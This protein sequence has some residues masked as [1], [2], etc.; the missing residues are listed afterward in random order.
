MTA[1]LT[2]LT[3]RP[4]QR[5]WAIL[6]AILVLGGWLRT[7]GLAKPFYVDEIT[8]LT[9]AVQPLDSM[10]EVMRKIDASPALYPSLLHFWLKVSHSD[11]WAR[12]LSAVFGTATILAAFGLARSAFGTR[13]AFWA[14]FVIAIAP[15]H[16]AYAQ[17]VRN[18]S[19]FTLLAL[20]QLW[21]FLR[22]VAA[23]EPDVRPS[24]RSYVFLMLATAAMF[25]THYL[26]LLVLIPEGLFALWRLRGRRRRVLESA[27]AMVIAG[28]VF[29]PGVS[30]LQ[31]NVEFDAR[32][33]VDRATPPPIHKVLP[34]LMGELTL[35][36]RE[37]GFSNPTVRRTVLS[38]GL[39][40]FGVL[41]G[42]GVIA[43][44]RRHREA[45]ILLGSFA[46]LPILAYVVSGRTIIATRF[47]LPFGAALLIVA[48]HGLASFGRRTA[49]V[50]ALALIVM[51]AIPIRHFARDFTW[52]YDHRTVA[53]AIADRWQPG[54]IILFVHPFEAFYYQWYLGIDRPVLGLTFTPLVEQ[55]TYV[56]KPAPLD[57]EA[58]KARV[59]AASRTH[60]RLWI[61]GQSRRSFTS[62]DEAQER[63]VAAWMDEHLGRLE[64]LGTLTGGAAMVR[65]YRG[66]PAGNAGTGGSRV[67]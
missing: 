61:V 24:P 47:F 35:G 51:C 63:E 3:S 54:D 29:L 8:T 64:D 21:A 19:L 26:S 9:V 60:D 32:R 23:G 20:L 39:V 33:N 41:L 43:G 5:S 65:L 57:V 4:S 48:A 40:L 28:L 44:W 46:V 12:L 6:L 37:L 18:Y 27:G 56:I 17:Y 16:V 11:E 34:D 31:H 7:L 15:V 2:S 66:R 14:A 1:T 30:L 38:A 22:C 67:P 53:A 62:S 59:L 13:T 25:Y 52:S 45:T 50:L 42:A 58:A 49:G 10:S 36:R 55:P